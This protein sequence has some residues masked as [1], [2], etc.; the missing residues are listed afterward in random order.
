MEQPDMRHTRPMPPDDPA[1]RPHWDAARE[2]TLL[3]QR[4]GHCGMHFFPASSTCQACRSPV[5]EWVRVAGT[6]IIESFC[7]FYKAYWPQMQDQL[8]YTVVQVRLDEGVRLM[9]NLDLAC[10]EISIG[11][12]VRP[13]FSR[14]DENLTLVN[15]IPAAE[16]TENQP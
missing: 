13:R 8:P 3:V 6:G 7:T 15:F 11:M 4:C 10:A 14:I 16:P 1:S 9:G 2:D 5:S 12:R